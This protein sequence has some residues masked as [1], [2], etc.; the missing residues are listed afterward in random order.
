MS[1]LLD[2]G[3]PWYAQ[4]QYPPSSILLPFAERDICFIYPCFCSQ[5]LV[6]WGGVRL[7]PI[8]TSTTNWPIVP[9][10]DVRWMWSSQWNQNWQGKQKY[11]EKP[12]PVPLYQPQIPRDLTWARTR[13]AAVGSRRL[14]AWAM[15]RPL[16]VCVY[17]NNRSVV[18]EYERERE[19][20]TYITYSRRV[21]E[22]E[23]SREMA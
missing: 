13:A 2:I 19:R 18:W 20:E 15:A 22:S 11:S 12:T 5:F 4:F 14:T 1:S 3:V 7:C 17:M 9:A 21:G 16:A 23:K 10:P 8:G 6:S